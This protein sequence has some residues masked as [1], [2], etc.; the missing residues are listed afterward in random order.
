[1]LQLGAGR[2]ALV[3]VSIV[4]ARRL[5]G[6]GLCASSPLHSEECGRTREFRFARERRAWRIPACDERDPAIGPYAGRAK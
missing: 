6:H 4:A 1:M 3:P 2:V 5:S